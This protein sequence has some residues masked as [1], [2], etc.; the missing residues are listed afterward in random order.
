MPRC[1]LRRQTFL[2]FL[3]RVSL[4]DDTSPLISLIFLG[5]QSLLFSIFLRSENVMKKAHGK[6]VPGKSEEK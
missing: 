5:S 3:Q 6:R 4:K 2:F 1:I